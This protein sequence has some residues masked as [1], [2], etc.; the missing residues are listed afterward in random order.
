[1]MLLSRKFFANEKD[2]SSSNPGKIIINMMVVAQ[3]P[4]A[5]LQRNVQSTT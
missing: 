5:F 1:M 4:L 3:K 2:C